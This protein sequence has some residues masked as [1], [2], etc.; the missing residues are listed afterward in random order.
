MQTTFDEELAGLK[1]KI[2]LMGARVE[3]AIGL[4][5]QSLVKR[6][7]KLC[8]RVIQNDRDIDD[9]EME[10]DEICHRILALYQPTAG[11]MRFVTSCMKINANLERM[12]DLAVDISER[13]LTVN[14]VEPLKPYI[15]IPQLAG[16][17][18]EMLKDSLNSLV[19]RDS[20]L[21]Q[22]V[23]ERDNQ[24]DQLNDQ[25][26]RV[27]ITYMLDDRAVIKQALDTV[28]ISRF[29]ERIADHAED[30]ALNVIY[31]LD[32]KN[33]HHQHAESKTEAQK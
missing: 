5:I 17:V 9:M 11:D 8:R 18:Q 16:I 7:S 23:R 15:D 1:E 14:K 31:M 10:V 32:G 28:L 26:I 2:L 6:D 24:V 20:D 27:L 3:E 4:S 29:L 33:L 12:G 22:K 21:A 30:I 13:A 19:N 25:I